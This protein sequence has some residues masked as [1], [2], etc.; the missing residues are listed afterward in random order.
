MKAKRL[1]YILTLIILILI[2]SISLLRIF[3]SRQIDDLHPLIN[4]NEKYLEKSEIVLVIPLFENKSVADNP[5]WCKNILALNKTLG[6]HGVYHTYKEFNSP[7]LQ[8]DLERGIEEF[9]KCFGLKPEIFEA[10]QWKLSKENKNILIKRG[11][12]IKGYYNAF[13]HKVYHCSDEGNFAYRLFG[14]KITNKLIDW[15]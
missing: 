12:E 1:F 8:E 9:E 10:P 13:T 15:I 14:I 6:I 11:F 7:I 4:C 3:N 5:E 2:L